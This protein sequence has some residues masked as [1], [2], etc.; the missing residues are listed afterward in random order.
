MFH[1]RL[2]VAGRHHDFSLK[3]LSEVP[4]HIV[5]QAT[6]ASAMWDML[7]WGTVDSG[8]LALLD[9]APLRA[10][11]AL[12]REWATDSG[13]TVEEVAQLLNLIDEHGGELEAD[14]IDKGMRLRD[15]PSERC[16][17]RDLHVIVR[18]SNAESRVFGVLEPDRAGWTK[19]T[20]L[21]ADI[22]DSNN[23]L[24][25]AKTKAATEGGEPPDRIPRPGVKPPERR[26][27][28][29]VK[30]S[31]I[32]TIDRLSGV[33]RGDRDSRATRLSKAFK[34]K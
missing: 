12:Y 20:M 13:I 19:A 16:N 18:H 22:A 31:T 17:W 4:R 26:K 8:Q 32:S 25:W 2:R 1:Y 28:S 10:I 27:G 11:K 7:N 23:W 14:L 15:F 30:P 33:D 6:R 34:R 24:Q 21:L 29:K 9:R 3:P 5:G